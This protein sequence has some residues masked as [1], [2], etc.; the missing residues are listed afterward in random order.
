MKEQLA[1][2]DEAKSSSAAVA[3]VKV[4]TKHLYLI[5][6]QQRLQVKTNNSLS[7]SK[8]EFVESIMC[9]DRSVCVNVSLRAF[10]SFCFRDCVVTCDTATAMSCIA[11]ISATQPLC[12]SLAG[13]QG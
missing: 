13:S 11:V 1:K 6:R 12:R 5:R 3:K 9:L 4:L 7:S 8:G 10:W 2:R